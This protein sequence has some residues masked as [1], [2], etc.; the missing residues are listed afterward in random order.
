[1]LRRQFLPSFKQLTVYII[2][3]GEYN[4]RIIS[5]SQVVIQRFVWYIN[6]LS[7]AVYQPCEH[8]GHWW[9]DIGWINSELRKIKET[10]RQAFQET[11]KIWIMW[12]WIKYFGMSCCPLRQPDLIMLWQRSQRS[13]PQ[14][15][16]HVQ[17]KICSPINL[18]FNLLTVGSTFW[19]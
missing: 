6:F 1:M 11:W 3:L 14:K 13:G 8:S 10:Q 17:N 16:F 18:L 4:S 2:L 15:I 19:A 9:R 7:A 5:S 12:P